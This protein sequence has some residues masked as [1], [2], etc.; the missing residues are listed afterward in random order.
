MKDGI[1]HLRLHDSRFG[2]TDLDFLLPQ[3]W[4]QAEIQKKR[5]ELERQVKAEP[6]NAPI[7]NELFDLYA[8]SNLYDQAISFYSSLLEADPKNILASCDLGRAY[9]HNNQ[10]DKALTQTDYSLSL[11]PGSLAELFNQGLYRVGNKNLVGAEESWQKSA[12]FGP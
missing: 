9:F 8:A 10:F 7:Q 3:A 11:N 2:Q 5:A 6:Q 1:H 4:A 12:V